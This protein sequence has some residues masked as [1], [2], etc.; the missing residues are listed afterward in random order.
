MPLSLNHASAHWRRSWSIVI[1]M[2][3]ALQAL[4]AADIGTPLGAGAG[5]ER[6]YV[7]AGAGVGACEVWISLR[8]C[9][10]SP[11]TLLHHL[12]ALAAPYGV[13]V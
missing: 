1:E 5:A 13:R 6:P 3:L 4:S 7:G 12:Q 10:P 9:E 8:I 11:A 2:Y